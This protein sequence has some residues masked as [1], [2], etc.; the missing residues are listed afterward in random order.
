MNKFTKYLF[1]ILAT[2]L[3]YFVFFHETKIVNE[4]SIKNEEK[5]GK[6]ED[7]TIAFG[8]NIERMKWKGHLKYASGPF[9]DLNII[10]KSFDLKK[11]LPHK[12]TITVIKINS[13]NLKQLPEELFEFKNLVA[14]DISDNS[15]TDLEKLMVDLAKFP[16]LELLAMNYCGIIKLPNNINLL[17]ELVGLSL[18]LNINMTEI[19]ENIG[20]LTK[21]RYLNLRRN[22][23]LN[24][25]PR[26]IGNLKCLEQIVIS[27]SGISRIREELSL[28]TNL[29]DITAN[30]SEI[31]TIP[32]NIGRLKRLKTLNLGYNRIENLPESIDNLKNVKSLSLSG[33]DLVELPSSITKLIQ[34]YSISLKLNRF[35]TF[36]S[37]VLELE[38]LRYLNLHNNYINEIPVE[39]AD[40]PNLK[41]V[42]VDHEIIT[43]ENIDSLRLRNPNLEVKLRDA[44]SLVPS[45]P[46]RKN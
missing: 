43:D 35:K 1:L 2:L 32:E 26:S 41:R 38:G 5:H 27:G 30:A 46:K 37:E 19:N 20:K 17:S 33:N 18:D 40:L 6:I 39:L 44:L 14:L 3:I 34:I 16:K 24:D 11:L 29:V 8:C 4:T 25:L 15:F 22:K 42:Y 9:Y 45:E 36:P 12:D 10:K 28:C 7:S 23:K 21:L 13:Q 31:K